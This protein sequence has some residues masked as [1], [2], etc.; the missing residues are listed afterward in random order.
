LK[1]PMSGVLVKSSPTEA[2]LGGSA[3]RGIIVVWGRKKKNGW[4]SIVESFYNLLGKRK[5]EK[6]IAFP[7]SFRYQG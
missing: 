7:K 6:H 3:K 2:V 5:C 1:I 4:A